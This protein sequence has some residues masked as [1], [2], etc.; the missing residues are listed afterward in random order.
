[1]EQAKCYGCKHF[2]HKENTPWCNVLDV[3]TNGLAPACFVV[4]R[5]NIYLKALLTRIYKKCRLN[6]FMFGD[7]KKLIDKYVNVPY[8]KPKDTN[9]TS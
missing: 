3:E 1:M 5:E 4:K 9:E 8:M 7:I 6:P 2:K